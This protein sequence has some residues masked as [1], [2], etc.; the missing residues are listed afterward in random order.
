MSLVLYKFKV[1]YT[2]FFLLQVSDRDATQELT[3]TSDK[4]EQDSSAGSDD[5]SQQKVKDEETKGFNDVV[6]MF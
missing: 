3:E 1:K 2:D 5:Q 4:P 6:M